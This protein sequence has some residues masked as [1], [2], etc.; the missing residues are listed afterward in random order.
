MN[1]L[2]LTRKGKNYVGAP[3]T[4]HGFEVAVAKITKSTFAGKEWPLHIPGEHM[5]DTVK[6]LMPDVDWVIDRDNN[7]LEPK[8]EGINV[9]HFISDL[10][11]KHYYDMRT[12]EGHITMLNNAGY[13]AIFMRYSEVYGTGSPSDI[14]KFLLPSAYWIPW[15]FDPNRFYPRPLRKYDVAFLGNVNAKVYPLR[16]LIRDELHQLGDKYKT[17]TSTSPKGKTFER[18]ISE[19]LAGDKYADVLGH[20]AISIF[21]CSIYRYPLQKFF[22]S[23]ASGC[24]VVS[25]K[26][27]GA[28]SLGLIDGLTYVE[29]NKDNWKKQLHY[30]LEN[31]TEG[32]KIADRGHKI[33]HKYHT[34]EVRAGQF[35]KCLERELNR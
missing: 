20:S 17:F 11:A 7:L 31:P 35:V 10:H 5:E 21:D 22:E 8:P 24:L 34:H 19:H 13:D 6:R 4:R 28:E 12:P 16:R 23:L 33:A 29:I 1:V 26:P 25:T 32:K 14:Y 30:Y 18:K 27:H 2:W 3:S 9:A 15:S